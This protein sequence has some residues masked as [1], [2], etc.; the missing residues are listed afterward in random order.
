M[1]PG[2]QPGRP[3][4]IDSNMTMSLVSLLLFLPLAI[5]AIVNAAKVKG[6]LRQGDYAGAQAAAAESKKWSKLATVLGIIS[7][8]VLVVCCGLAALGL[9]GNLTTKS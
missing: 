9:F 3:P 8:G 6:L 4:Q 1:Q 7:Y 2:D 5:P